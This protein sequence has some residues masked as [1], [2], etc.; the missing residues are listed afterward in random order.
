MS[1]CPSA[2]GGSIRCPSVDGQSECGL[3]CGR[4]KQNRRN[5]QLVPTYRDQ[6]A[7]GH[8]MCYGLGF[9]YIVTKAKT[10]IGVMIHKKK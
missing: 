3:T 5:V 10:S 6:L 9:Y 1:I 7:N 8:S 2:D 4:Q